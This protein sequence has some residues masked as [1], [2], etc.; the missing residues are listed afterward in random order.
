MLPVLEEGLFG[1]VDRNRPL[2]PPRRKG[3]FEA[4]ERRERRPL[5]PAGREGTGRTPRGLGADDDDDG[6]GGDGGGGDGGGGKVR[7]GVGRDEVFSALFSALTIDVGISRFIGPGGAFGDSSPPTAALSPVCR[8]RCGGG[9]WSCMNGDDLSTSSLGASSL[10][11]SSFFS[12]SSSGIIPGDR[13][14]PAGADEGTF[15]GD[16]KDSFS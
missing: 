6:G 4:G 12:S 5:K 9:S 7:F 14:P 16:G 11:C 10:L 8:F 15:E 3:N 13:C 2:S 1:K